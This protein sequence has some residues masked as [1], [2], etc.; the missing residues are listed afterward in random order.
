MWCSLQP[1]GREEAQRGRPELPHE[2][3]QPHTQRVRTHLTQP[4][5]IAP[6][7]RGPPERANGN[8]SR[9]LLVP[10]VVQRSD[11]LQSNLF[12]AQTSITQWKKTAQHTANTA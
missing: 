5:V 4:A 7:N 2:R 11:T 3:A 6:R 9:Q 12:L 10:E 1:A 8:R